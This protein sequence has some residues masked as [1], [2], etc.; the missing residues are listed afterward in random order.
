MPSL[1]QCTMTQ[2]EKEVEAV[3]SVIIP[4]GSLEEHGPHLPLATDTI[5]AVELAQLTA[6]K[7]PV[8]VAPA[9]PYGLC[10]SSSGHPGTVGIGANTLQGIIIDLV[11]GLYRQGL[12][13]VVLLSGHAGGT[14]MAAL[15]D[16]G[17]RLMEQLGELRMAVLSVL[18]LGRKAWKGLQE[19]PG[20]SHAGEVE[21]S[22]ILELHPELVRGTAPEEYPSFPRHILVRNKRAFWHG[23]VWGNPGKASAEKGRRLLER[24]AEALAALIL[25]LQQWVEPR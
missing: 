3:T 23:G 19:T 7:V 24:S 2:F 5:H 10:R 14:H 21:T 25:E 12:R 18:D 9:I 22:L 16:A 6:R 13:Q 15:I 1:E 20:D 11:T 8:W 4:I 17:E